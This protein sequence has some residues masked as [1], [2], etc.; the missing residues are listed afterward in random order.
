[1]QIRPNFSKSEWLINIGD[2]KSLKE[3][4]VQKRCNASGNGL[5]NIPSGTFFTYAGRYHEFTGL[6]IEKLMKNNRSANTFIHI[7]F[8]I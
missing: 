6:A 2:K 5:A 4:L 7:R 3:K 8:I 1:M